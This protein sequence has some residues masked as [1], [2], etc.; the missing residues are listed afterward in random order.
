MCTTNKQDIRYIHFHIP[1]RSSFP[2]KSSMKRMHNAEEVESENTEDRKSAKRSVGTQAR[3]VFFIYIFF[4]FLLMAN[5]YSRLF[6][7]FSV[8]FFFLCFIS[9]ATSLL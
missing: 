3:L 7:W 5:F 4:F 8:V 9:S 2:K 1:T 6:K